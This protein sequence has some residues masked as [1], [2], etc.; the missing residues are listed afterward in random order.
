MGKKSINP[1]DKHVGARIRMQRMLRGLSQTELGKVIGVTFQQVQKYEKGK[2][3]VSSSRLQ[4]MADVLKSGRNFF[5]G[6]SA[7]PVADSRST[8]TALVEGFISSPDGIVLCKALPSI[9][10]AKMRRSIVALVKQLAEVS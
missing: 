10:D 9:T 5:D 6:T 2:N 8:E 1:T 7:K 4:Q 3:R